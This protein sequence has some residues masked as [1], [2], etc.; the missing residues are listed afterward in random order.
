MVHKK[1]GFVALIT[2]FLLLSSG[3]TARW[4]E[5]PSPQVKDLVN[6]LKLDGFECKAGSDEVVCKQGVPFC[7]KQPALC[8][9]KNVAFCEKNPSLCVSNTGCIAQPYFLIYNLY[10]LKQQGNGIP[11]IRQEIERKRDDDSF[12]PDKIKN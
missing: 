7:E 1:V 8:D 9:S 12:C 10:F 5:E 2:G 6:D 11:A 3:C 4:I